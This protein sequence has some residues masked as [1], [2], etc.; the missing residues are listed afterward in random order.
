MDFKIFSE[1][2]AV[3]YKPTVPTFAIRIFN[4]Y[5]V[6]WRDLRKTGLYVGETHHFFDDVTPFD[7]EPG[8]VLFSDAMALSMLEDIVLLPKGTQA[9]MIHCALGAS[10]SPAVAVALNEVFNYGHDE[11]WAQYGNHNIWV[12]EKLIQNAQYMGLMPIQ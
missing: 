8:L 4:S 7:T 1:D 11:L 3:R 12:R 9:L 6:G 2:M 5:R 10:R